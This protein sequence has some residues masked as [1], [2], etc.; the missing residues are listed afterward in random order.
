L[1]A[2]MTV[3][4]VAGAGGG[5]CAIAAWLQ[6]MAPSNID[7]VMRSCIASSHSTE[8]FCAARDGS[9]SLDRA[10]PPVHNTPRAI[11]ESI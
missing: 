7:P 1:V 4:T 9:T 2:A 11:A 3:R 5:L 8:L 10:R 6:A